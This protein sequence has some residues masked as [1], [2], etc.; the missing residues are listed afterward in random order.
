VVSVR[1]KPNS[2]SRLEVRHTNVG[3]GFCMNEPDGKGYVLD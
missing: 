3:Q 2:S 1:D